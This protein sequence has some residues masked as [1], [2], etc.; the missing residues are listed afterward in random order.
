MADNA[1]ILETV[2]KLDKTD[3]TQ[4]TDDG[5]PR[6][7]VVKALVDDSTLTRAQ[8]NE[9]APGFSR[10]PPTPKGDETGGA[11]PASTIQTG[12]ESI[13]D[14]EFDA[15]IEPEVNGPGEQ[16]TEDQ[17][18]AILTRRIG[19][20]E[21][22]LERA[23]A[24]VNEANAELR[25]CEVRVQRAITDSNRRFPPISAAANIK[26]HLAA[27]Q[28]RLIA[29]VQARGDYGTGQLDQAMQR[30]NSRGWSR[31][32]RPVQNASAAA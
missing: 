6:V 28:A 25:R 8:I 14:D 27:Q 17:V 11:P 15:R 20:A 24:D 18:R 30:R 5:L 3:D 19:D 13:P 2:T 29:E 26:Q 9:A 22:R 10:N 1:K 12:D 23:R 7:E 4:W 16:L 21:T 32:S 31:P